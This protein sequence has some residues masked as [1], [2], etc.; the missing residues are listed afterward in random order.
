M[1]LSNSCRHSPQMINSAMAAKVAQK[2]WL[3]VI[4]II[5][6]KTSP[7][8]EA[9]HLWNIFRACGATFRA[10][11]NTA[12]IVFQ[13]SSYSCRHDPHRLNLAIRTGSTMN[14]FVRIRKDNPKKHAKQPTGQNFSSFRFQYII[15]FVKIHQFGVWHAHVWHVTLLLSQFGSDPLEKMSVTPSQNGQ[16]DA[17]ITE[18][19]N[20]IFIY[21]HHNPSC[22]FAC[23]LLHHPDCK[24][25]AN[26]DVAPLHLRQRFTI[27]VAFSRPKRQQV[28]FVF[29]HKKQHPVISSKW[30]FFGIR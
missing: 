18:R 9:D 24:P 25:P 1:S 12:T 4:I 6:P 30:R 14:L 13:G 15:Q 16:K 2:V 20:L 3:V 7:Y 19:R 17:K 28:G 26:R 11:K 8:F 10:W 22:I 27:V 5:V 23:K 21:F 29:P